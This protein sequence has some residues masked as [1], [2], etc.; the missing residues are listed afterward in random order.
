M[1]FIA[2]RRQE[3]SVDQLLVDHLTEVGKLAARFAEKIRLPHCGRLLGLLHDFGKYSRDFQNYI[4]SANGMI[5]QDDETWVDARLQKGKIDHSSAGAQYVWKKLSKIGGNAKQG[6]LCGQILA[7]CIA[8]HHSGLIDCLDKEGKDKFSLRMKK[9]DTKTHLQEATRNADRLIIQRADT[10]LGLDLVKTMFSAIRKVA[11]FSKQTSAGELPIPDMFNLGLFTRFLFSCLVDADRINS[12]E[13]EMPYKQK[14]RIN[15]NAYFDWSIAIKRLEK[16]LASLGVEQPIDRI[17]AKISNQCQRRASEQKGIYTLSVPTGGGK[18]LASLRY[19]LRHA[20][21][22]KMDRIIYIIPF[23]AIIEQNADSVRRIVESDSDAFPWVLEHHSN[24]EP[25]KQ[26][27]RTKLIAE[28]WDA[29][30]IF[31]TMV[32]FLEVLF[33]GGTRGVRRMHHL[34]NAVLVFDEIQC[35]PMRCVYMFCNALNFLTQ[36][37]GATAV[38]CS[39]TQP[40]LDKLPRSDYGQLKLA[41]HPELVENKRRLFVDLKRVKVDN[42]CK[43]G[44]WALAE[45][46]DLV[47]RRFTEKRCCLVIVNTKAWARRL[48]EEMQQQIEENTL[49][50]LS[51]NQCPAHRKSLFEKIKQRLREKQPILCISTQLIEAGVDIDFNHVVRFLAGLDSITQAAGRC[52]RNGRLKDENGNSIPGLIDVINPTEES[53]QTL[54]DIIEG[55]DKTQRIFN[56]FKRDDILSPEAMDCYYQYY[57]FDRQQVLIYPYKQDCLL[58]KLANNDQNPGSHKNRERRR[59]RKVPLLQQSFMAVGQAFRAI[60][61][62]NHSIIVPFGKGDEIIKALCALDR[63]FEAKAF[64][65]L[66]KEAQQYSV[67]VFPNIWNRLK[68]A[69]AVYEIQHEGIYYLRESYYNS[70]FGLMSEETEKMA[71]QY[72]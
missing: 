47:H 9:C 56:E 66:L 60:D 8:S 28:N 1:H 10:L 55:K 30:I 2:H 61:A 32:Q 20:D 15:R 72:C 54:R 17:R 31:T 13:F 22:H 71:F 18:T 5:D 24:I 34:A 11:D 48:Y 16:H 4:K 52:N 50:H 19:A 7:L 69:G 27:W 46:V 37:A 53:I 67:N 23:T 44:G 3:D 49:F 62:P 43:P 29:P 58:N 70:K 51:T 59:N 25:E 63:K 12:A 40:L 33:A 21:T 65:Q 35:L 57:F 14:E 36:Q 45:I 39:A 41:K 68:Q 38:L 64:Y 6:E 26:T 42:Q